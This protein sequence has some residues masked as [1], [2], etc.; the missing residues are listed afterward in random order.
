MAD[1][2]QWLDRIEAVV[3]PVLASRGLDLVDTEDRPKDVELVRGDIRDQRLDLLAEVVHG[4]I[5][6][7]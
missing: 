6:G 4:P 3:A 2:A 1:D 5:F 7:R